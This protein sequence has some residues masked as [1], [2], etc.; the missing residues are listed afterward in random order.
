MLVRLFAC[1]VGWKRYNVTT[2]ETSMNRHIAFWR[3][4][5]VAAIFILSIIASA[6]ASA[7]TRDRAAPT[8]PTNLHVTSLTSHNVT[9]GWSPSSDDSG[10]LSYRLWV[11][12]GFTYTV[13]QALTS[14]S[15]GVVPSNTYSFYV[16]AVDGSGNA[17][18]KSNTVTVTTPADTTA[19]TAPVL[20][21]D[22]ANPTEIS[23]M[24]TAS[25][26][27][28][29]YVLYQVFV[30]GSPNVDA[31]QKLSAVVHGL[32]PQTSYAI[33]VRARD[34]YGQNVSAPSNVLNVTTPA[35]SVV[36]NEAPSSPGDLNGYDVGD[37]AREINLFW[38]ESFDDQTPQASIVYEVYLNGVLDH[39]TGGDRT[40]LYANRGGEN[41]FTVIAVDHAG[42][43]SQ[44][45]GITIVSQ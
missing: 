1:Q 9:L 37:G 43:R 39:T 27:D 36:D 11:S 12:Y 42:N 23:L 28:G 34:L 25:H 31:G 19:P 7:A 6:P 32:T 4:G 5:S 13:S 45:A 38:K 10:V 41:T 24:W 21:L 16:Y 3:T 40:I 35:V 26:D 22:D 44:P 14:F 2:E 29:P 20:S 30:N 8:K 15:L 17:S 18:A 33:T